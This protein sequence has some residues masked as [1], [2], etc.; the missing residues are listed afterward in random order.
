[1]TCP[2]CGVEQPD[3]AECVKCGIVIARARS[4]R[5]LHSAAPTHPVPVRRKASRGPGRL[6][7]LIGLAVPF[8]TLAVIVRT[9]TRPAAVK[10]PAPDDLVPARGADAVAWPVCDGRAPAPLGR[11]SARWYEEQDFKAALLEQDA[12]A[13]PILVYIYTDWCPYCKAFNRDVLSDRQV[14]EYLAGHMVKVRINPEKSPEADRLARRLGATGFPTL[15]LIN[16]L[17]QTTNFERSD[18]PQEF[19]TRLD[20]AIKRQTTRACRSRS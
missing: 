2:R 3:A 1:M 5:P 4:S 18:E 17:R 6:L 10:G 20:R 12:T 9:L 8:F 19:I 15:V 11:V 16:P 7:W 13:V 14:A